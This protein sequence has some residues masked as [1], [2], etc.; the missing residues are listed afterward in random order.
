MAKI[1]I[2]GAGFAGHTAAMYLGDAI[3][4]RHEITVVNKR[5]YFLFLPSLIWVSIK[6]MKPEKTHF[7]LKPVYDKFNVNFF[8]GSVTE[9]HPDKKFL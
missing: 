8:K 5:D 6:R 7:P 2:I 9:V 1:V 3:G 4:K